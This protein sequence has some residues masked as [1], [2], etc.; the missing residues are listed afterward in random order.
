M[1]KVTAPTLRRLMENDRTLVELRVSPNRISTRPE[2]ATIF[3][4][5]DAGWR[6]AG[7]IVGNSAVLSALA[8]YEP[9]GTRHGDGSIERLGAFFDGAGRNTNIDRLS[10]VGLRAFGGAPFSL[11]VP[12]LENNCNLATLRVSD[13][14][15]GD[16]GVRLLA[17]ALSSC[18]CHGMECIALCDCSVDDGEPFEE[19]VS[20]LYHGSVSRPR[21]KCT[22]HELDLQGNNI[23]RNGCA[24][25]AKMLANRGCELQTLL[26][27]DNFIDN[28]GISSLKYGLANN[29]SL[30]TLDIAR[31]NS[32]TGEG[33]SAL[34][35]CLCNVKTINS[36]FLSNHS[37]KI[38]GHTR[39]MKLPKDLLYYLQLNGKTSVGK[40]RFAPIQKILDNHHGWD[41]SQFMEEELQ[42][43]P[44]LI[45]WFD[46]AVVANRISDGITTD[47]RK[48]NVVVLRRRRMSTIHQFVCAM[49]LVVVDKLLDN[50]E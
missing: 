45:C 7:E 22:L 9:P 19:F 43:L 5:G 16:D 3:P 39:R 2:I 31:E 42:F 33:W 6:V 37:L 35:K 40:K 38:V 14:S 49:P 24:A 17:R 30:E 1:N 23:G 32:I 8:V 28:V 20:A 10:F 36:T 25:L 41:M 48:R 44:Y 27:K 47:R 29:E 11:M 18:R 26:L 21:Q 15:L 13:S 50:K 46:R 4:R 34:S 12:L